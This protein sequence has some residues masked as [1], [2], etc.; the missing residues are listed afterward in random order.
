MSRW[1]DTDFRL[2]NKMGV[3]ELGTNLGPNW[4]F[5]RGPT[6]PMYRTEL[7]IMMKVIFYMLQKTPQSEKYVWM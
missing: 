7:V 3:G 4:H 5:F 1:S 2:V 6:P